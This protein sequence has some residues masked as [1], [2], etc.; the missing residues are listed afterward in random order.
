MHRQVKQELQGDSGLIKIVRLRHLPR[1]VEMARLAQVS[2]DTLGLDYTDI[3]LVLGKLLEVEYELY[4]QKQQALVDNFF[5][6]ADIDADPSKFPV[7]RAILD[8]FKLDVAAGINP[9]LALKGI[10]LIASSLA[11]SNRQSRVSR[12]G[13][14][15]MHHLD[16]LLQKNGF[17]YR[18][19]FQR[20]FVLTNGCKLDFFFPDAANYL[21]EPK[22]CC[23]IACQT[24]SNDRFR[25]TFAQMPNDTRNR[26]CTAIGSAN[27]GLKLGPSSLTT[28]KLLEAKSEGVKFVIFETAIDQRLKDSAAVMSYNDWFAEL[29][30]L[31]AF[32]K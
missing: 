8:K 22:N 29:G 6:F 20:E 14:S 21:A 25:L 30:A 10:N 27:F 2:V 18:V 13:S 16:Y 26:A 12:S 5:E 24:T 23:A 32:W 7:V 11:D 15:L 31:K 4:L 1:T 3:D 9:T 28:Q 19:D 17:R